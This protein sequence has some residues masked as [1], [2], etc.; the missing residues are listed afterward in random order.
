MR[1][2]WFDTLLDLWIHCTWGSL[3]SVVLGI[4]FGWWVG[5]LATAAVWLV[6]HAVDR[7]AGRL[8][9]RPRQTH[10]KQRGFLAIA[11]ASQHPQHAVRG[12]ELA[13]FGVRRRPVD[14]K[15]QT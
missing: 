13:S 15:F 10:V 6:L 12:N 11:D 8:I 14:F 1:T 5:L 3:A 7:G 4:A 2:H 9:R